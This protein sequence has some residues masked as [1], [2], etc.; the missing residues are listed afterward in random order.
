MEVI[1]YFMKLINDFTTK[2]FYSYAKM[3]DCPSDDIWSC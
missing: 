1:V 2:S 3:I